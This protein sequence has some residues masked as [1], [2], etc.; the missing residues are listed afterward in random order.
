M[1]NIFSSDQNL[2]DGKLSIHH[3]SVFSQLMLLPVSCIL[4]SCSLNMFCSAF[5]I[6]KSPLHEGKFHRDK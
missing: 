1:L 2:E 4:T 6:L 3:P 5:E